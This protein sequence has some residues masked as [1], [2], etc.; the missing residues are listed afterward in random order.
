MASVPTDFAAAPS[1]LL[2]CPL[3]PRQVGVMGGAFPVTND[4][5]M[6]RLARRGGNAGDTARVMMLADLEVRRLPC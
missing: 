4:D 2:P 5:F 6:A 1:P 3:W